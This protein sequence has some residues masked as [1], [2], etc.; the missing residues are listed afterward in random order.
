MSSRRSGETKADKFAALKAARGGASRLK[1]YKP[2]EA[3]IYDSVSEDQYKQI[4]G[5]RLAKDDF[6]EDDDGGGYQD[7]GMDDWD[8]ER[9]SDSEEETTKRKGS[10]TSKTVKTAAK[11]AK[12]NGKPKPPVTQPIKMTAYRPQVSEAKEQDFLANLL[13]GIDSTTTST[14]PSSPPSLSSSTRRKRK[15]SPDYAYTSGSG[16]GS[17]DTMAM[18]SSDADGFGFEVEE[19]RMSFPTETRPPDSAKKQRL[20]RF[21]YE[22]NGDDTP[23][24]VSFADDMMPDHIDDSM[25]VDDEPEVKV[26]PEQMDE[27]DDF[28]LAA[29]GSTVTRPNQSSAKDRLLA[30]MRKGGKK[31]A[32]GP[33][34]PTPATKSRRNLVNSTSVSV[35][36][37][38]QLEAQARAQKEA[39]DLASLVNEEEKA[40]APP[41]GT[42]KKENPGA[43][44]RRKNLMAMMNTLNSG[45]AEAEPMGTP[46]TENQA[47][48]KQYIP[49]IKV[50]AFEPLLDENGEEIEVEED[51]THA[52]KGRGK[53]KKQQEEEESTQPERTLRMYWLDYLETN[54][55]VHLIGKALDKIT[56][57]YI[58]CCVTIH[59]IER[60]L[61]VLP[62][63]RRQDEDG[64]DEE[65]SMS[66]VHSELDSIRRQ[67]DIKGVFG[68]KKVLRKYAF[69]LPEV[70]RGE[71][72]WYKVVYGFDQPAMPS[73]TEGATFSKIFGT[74]T[75]AFELLV[76]KRKIMG[77]CWLEIKGC[78]RKTVDP[79]SWC[80]L[81]VKVDD[82]KNV[83]PFPETDQTA[84]KNIP[85]LT[86]MS[87]AV[88]T[89]VNHEANNQEILAV[90]TSVWETYNI[91]DPTPPEKI[92]HTPYTIVRPLG[93][94]FPPNFEQRCRNERQMATARG[95]REMLN[96]VLNIFTKTDPDVIVGHEFFGA[97]FEVLLQRM[98][99]LKVDHWSRIGRFRRKNLTIAKHWNNNT[100]LAAGRLIADLSGDGAKG[101]IDSVTWSLTEMCQNQLGFTREE[102]DPDDTA[103]FFD[104]FA[105]TPD[106][107]LHFIRHLQMDAYAQ[108]AIA[109]KVQYLPL[110][111]QLTN[112]AGNS[113]NRTLTGARAERNEYILLHEFHR[114]KYICPDKGE[115]KPTSRSAKKVNKD[116]DG[117][118]IPEQ[119]RAKYQGGLVFEPKRGLWDTYILVMDFNSLYPSIIQE[120]N[121]DFTTIDRHDDE[122]AIEDEIPEVP[123]S[124]VPQGVLPR[125]IATLVNRRKQVKSLM[126]DKAA[127][128]VK[129]LQWDIKQKAL[130]LTA[131]SMYGCLGFAGSRFYARPLAALTTFKG[132]EILTQ[133]KE[134]AEGLSLDVVYGDTDSV[135]VN[136]NVTNYQEAIKI[137]NDF[138]RHVNDRYRLLEIDLD[139]VFARVLLLQKKKYAAVKISEDGTAK[140]EIKGLDMV[141]REYCKLSK[142][143]SSRVL[144][145]IL[146][147]RPTE[148]VVNEI[149]EYLTTMGNDLREGRV[150]LD[151]LIVHKRLGKNPEDYPDKG[152]QPHVQVALRMKQKGTTV[153]AGDVVPYLFCLGPDGKTAKSAQADRAYHPDEFRKPDSELKLDFDFYLTQQVLPPIERLCNDIEGTDRAR[154]AECL[155][156]DP[157]RFQNNSNSA[158]QEKEIFTFSSQISDKERFRD[159][160]PLTLRC[161]A[162]K[163]VFVF[164]PIVEDMESTGNIQN[165]GISCTCGQL[166]ST[167]SVSVQVELQLRAHISKYYEAVLCCSDCGEKTRSMSVYGKR[168]ISRPN[169][170]G[171]MRVQYTDSQLYNQ[172]LYYAY[173]FD[174]EKA[175]S[176]TRGTSKSEEAQALALHNKGAFDQ[177]HGMINGYLD[178]CARRYIDM[179]SLFGFMEKLKV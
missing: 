44:A 115:G 167:G 6:I 105:V 107:L 124:D 112:L 30:A 55:V 152:T 89:I 11:P 119:K 41:N 38:A 134:L 165:E 90:T 71:N 157:T 62:R 33:S 92:Y 49:R 121:I 35:A 43:A 100:K 148:E 145:H 39:E 130:K 3:E 15:S 118:V 174:V 32:N 172:L 160:D 22:P 179:K 54:G 142:N 161:R 9:Y 97:T 67:H 36:K 116:E 7:N 141:R 18:A 96:Y 122:T 135:F 128:Q 110:T 2:Q 111:K 80:R 66:E 136:S 144:E 10:R 1:Q 99:E 24:G 77:P 137:A 48:S 47:S 25:E 14:I 69:E 127:G 57:K 149:H 164:N 42:A 154:L 168:C 104:S 95:E 23:R 114:L 5:D 133:T 126:K 52:S 29:A 68:V 166:Q 140:T 123:G 8:E 74:N 31:D 101:M 147:G 86:V 19:K 75:S 64:D 87:L 12:T 61:F 91:D 131:N 156:L 171:E 102:I 70:P 153:K 139:N 120:F 162:C 146:S 13:S 173:L 51:Y 56:G 40:Q 88:R 46:F 53:T 76:L 108:M 158:F 16:L 28:R 83:N 169:C 155:G 109:S 72:E 79:A 138:K 73:N 60:N 132:R 143:V 113:W 103:G 37:Q 27:E 170:R 45:E 34:T 151:D 58:S 125:L 117:T 4:V 159:A 178:R 17:E 94:K 106:R 84:P 176:A 65:V 93:E 150:E 85:P 21:K 50:D 177:I 26:K 81:E 20:G 98:K 175:I 63:S 59:G 163:S 82:P 129:M 78:I